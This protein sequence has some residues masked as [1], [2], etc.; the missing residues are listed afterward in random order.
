MP[1]ISFVAIFVFSFKEAGNGLTPCLTM[2]QAPFYPEI[3]LSPALPD[4]SNGSIRP[5][6]F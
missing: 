5:E 6:L 1:F 4:Q 3:L 2:V